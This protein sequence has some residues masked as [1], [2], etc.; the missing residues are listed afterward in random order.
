MLHVQGSIKAVWDLSGWR[1][2][3]I[4]FFNLRIHTGGEK[5]DPP[6][7][8]FKKIANKNAIKFKNDMGPHFFKAPSIGPS[9][10][11]RSKTSWTLPWI[12]NPCASVVTVKSCALSYLSAHLK[13]FLCDC[14]TE[15]ATK[16]KLFW[17]RQP[18]KGRRKER[19]KEDKNNR[20]LL[21]RPFHPL[22][23]SDYPVFK[24]WTEDW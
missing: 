16:R 8:I 23:Q 20:K 24:N 5:T 18:L 6:K 1:F 14:W 22:S 3:L 17:K 7:K 11:K 9:L 10:K 12:F 13:W 2:K 15:L 19:K 21:A 4:K